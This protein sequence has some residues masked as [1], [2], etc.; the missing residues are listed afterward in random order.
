[1]NHIPSKK[2]V[3]V[4]MNYRHH[5][6]A[7]SHDVLVDGCWFMAPELLFGIASRETAWGDTSCYR[8]I[9]GTPR[10][11]S[12]DVGDYSKRRG[13]SQARYHG[14]GFFQFD[15]GAWSKWIATGQWKDVFVAARKAGYLLRDNYRYLDKRRFKIDIARS[16]KYLPKSDNDLIIRGAIAGYNCGVGNSYKALLRC[17]DADRFT[18]GR[19]YS[20]DVLDLSEWYWQNLLKPPEAG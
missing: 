10:D 5:V 20:K 2:E 1:M 14:Y 9:Y 11:K 19:D 6:M 13:E 16:K 18:T 7:A 3:N 12:D 17:L 4:A 15:I 8:D